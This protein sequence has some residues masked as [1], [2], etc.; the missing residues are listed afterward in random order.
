MRR[1]EKGLLVGSAISEVRNDEVDV[2]KTAQKPAIPGHVSESHGLK[3]EKI[4][5]EVIHNR[6]SLCLGGLSGRRG[7]GD[8]ANRCA[9][10]WLESAS[11]DRSVNLHLR[12]RPLTSNISKN[13]LNR[14]SCSSWR[15]KTRGRR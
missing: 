8:V 11:A 9:A 5:A 14:R 12:G 3:Q 10:G 13:R 1:K 7:D 4:L 6:F 15:R 2:S